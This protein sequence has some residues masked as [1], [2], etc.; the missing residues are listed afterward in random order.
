MKSGEAD[1]APIHDIEAVGLE[2]DPV[3]NVHVVELAV[4]DMDEAPL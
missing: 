1:I 3:E 4:G 2:G